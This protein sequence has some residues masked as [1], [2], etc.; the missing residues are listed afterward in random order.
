LRISFSASR[1]FRRLWISTPAA[2]VA[3]N[4]GR[5]RKLKH[6]C[7]RVP[8]NAKPPPNLRS[9]KRWFWNWRA[10]NGSRSARTALRTDRLVRAKPT[11]LALGLAACQRGHSVAFTTAAAL[12]HEL[13]EARDERRL[14]ALQK[15]LN[16]VKLLIVDELGYVPFTAVGS[17][18]LFEVF[19]QRYERGATLENNPHRRGT[20]QADS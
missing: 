2:H 11:V 7:N 10:V 1:L 3:G 16:T 4:R 15:H 6:L 14:R 18:L 17:E 5:N 19:S 9:T 8:V 20:R 12:V 13:M